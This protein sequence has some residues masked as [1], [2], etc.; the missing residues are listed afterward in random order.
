MGKVYKAF[1]M[2]L[3]PGTQEEYKRRHDEIWPDLE[4]LLVDAGVVMYKIYLDDRSNCLFAIQE[5]AGNNTI[6][7]LPNN[8]V[9]RKWW[10]FMADLMETNPDSSPVVF[11]LAEVFSLH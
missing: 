5:L 3:K 8:P 10:S 2:K 4:K 1:V 6:E 7:L 11:P 9:M